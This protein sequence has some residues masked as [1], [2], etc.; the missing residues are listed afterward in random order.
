MLHLL[1]FPDSSWTFCSVLSLFSLC[2]SVWEEYLPIFKFTNSF[3]SLVKYTVFLFPAFS[4][5]YFLD[6][7]SLHSYYPSIFASVFLYFSTTFLYIF[8]CI[9]IY[10][11]PVLSFIFPPQQSP[12][13]CLSHEFSSFFSFLL[14]HTY[15]L[16]APLPPTHIH[17]S[18][19]SAHSLSMDLSLFC[20]LVEFVH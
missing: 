10:K 17:T 19:L 8:F 1:K 3:L 12:H 7:S 15:T 18:E 4:L 2:I 9:T 20:F 6:F 14:N 16:S 13:C 5:D 11:P